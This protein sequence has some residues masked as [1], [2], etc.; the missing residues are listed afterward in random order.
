VKGAQF[1]NVI[2]GKEGQFI[3]LEGIFTPE[4]TGDD[5]PKPAA[6]SHLDEG[7]TLEWVVGDLPMRLINE[8]LGKVIG[9]DIRRYATAQ[10]LYRQP[11]LLM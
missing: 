6:V 11:G 5:L 2:V 9:R 4:P 10:F 3:E 1:E 7:A 8:R